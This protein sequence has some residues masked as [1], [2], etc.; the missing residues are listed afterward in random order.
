MFTTAGRC[1]IDIELDG[2]HLASIP[3]QVIVLRNAPHT[4]P[5]T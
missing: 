1:R 3:F 2:E 5:A 4:V